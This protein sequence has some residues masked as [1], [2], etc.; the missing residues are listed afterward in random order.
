MFAAIDSP[1]M[2][3][4]SAKGFDSDGN[5]YWIDAWSALTPSERRSVRSFPRPVILQRL[6]ESLL[7]SEF[8]PF[9]SHILTAFERLKLENPHVDLHI[10]P[11]IRIDEPIYRVREPEDPQLA[12]HQI[13]SFQKIRLQMWRLRFDARRTHLWSEPLIGPIEVER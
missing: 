6:A 5:R 12:E 7:T 9:E 1:S 10:S 13:K 8:V 2:R 11:T 3:V 4:I